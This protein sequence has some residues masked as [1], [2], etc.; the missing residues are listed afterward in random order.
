MQGEEVC[1]KLKQAIALAGHPIELVTVTRRSQRS[2]KRQP[3]LPDLT[4]EANGHKVLQRC[5][6]MS[7]AR[8]GGRFS[9][10]CA[11]KAAGVF[12]VAACSGHADVRWA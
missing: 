4:Q 9:D 2:A 6:A 12:Y 5:A 1:C 3:L 8:D 10:T 7:S 11:Y